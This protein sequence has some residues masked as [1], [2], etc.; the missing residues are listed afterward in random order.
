[1][2]RAYT[3]EEVREQLLDHIRNLARFWATTENRQTTLERCEGLAFSI[4]NIFDGTTE[5]PALDIVLA[6]HPD[7]T[8]FH[9][10]EGENW[11]EPGMMINDCMLHELFYIRDTSADIQAKA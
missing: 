7:D 11:Y 2:S 1:M 3:A 8:E 10:S 6:P 9:Q 5:F 4:L